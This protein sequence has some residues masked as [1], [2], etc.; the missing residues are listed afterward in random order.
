MLKRCEF[1]PDLC[2]LSFVWCDGNGH[3]SLPP[4]AY[5]RNASSSN[6]GYPLLLSDTNYTIRW[7]AK[8]QSLTDVPVQLTWLIDDHSNLHWETNVT[9]TEFIFNP[10]EILN[11]FPT[12]RSPSTSIGDAWYAA[13]QFPSV[14][15]IFRADVNPS[16]VDGLLGDRSQEFIV[17]SYQTEEYLSTQVQL[18]YNKW[19]FGVGLGVGLGVPFL[20]ALAVLATWLVCKKTMTKSVGKRAEATPQ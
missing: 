3:C 1:H 15:S 16:R 17:Q 5:P 2:L 4:G 7:Q 13:S 18:E 19:K 8:N 9:G 14:I 20:L 12:P 6:T 10:G 11:S